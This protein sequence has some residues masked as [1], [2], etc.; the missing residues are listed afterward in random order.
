MCSSDLFLTSGS[1]GTITSN[2]G[3]SQT[4]TAG[5][6]MLQPIIGGVGGSGS[7]PGGIG[8]GGGFNTGK[9]GQGLVLIA[10]W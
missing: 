10:S 1:S 3:Y 2:Y 9:G 8:C 5:F 6:F 7:L 4:N